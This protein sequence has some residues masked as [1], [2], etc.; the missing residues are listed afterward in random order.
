MTHLT[1]LRLTD[2]RNY[3]TL[4]LALDGR[5]VCLHGPNGAGKTNLLEAISQ[6]GPGRGLRSAAIQEL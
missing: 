1:R 5:H 6:L 3:E 2:F 4:D